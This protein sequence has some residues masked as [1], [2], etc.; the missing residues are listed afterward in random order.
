MYLTIY[1]V[2]YIH[3]ALQGIFDRPCGNACCSPLS[4]MGAGHAPCQLISSA[5]IEY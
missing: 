1:K 4:G 5:F 3:V 2:L